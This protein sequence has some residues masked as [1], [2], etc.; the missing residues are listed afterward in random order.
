MRFQELEEHFQTVEKSMKQI[1]ELSQ[2]EDKNYNQ[3]V[4]WVD[5]K[6]LHA[7]KIQEIV[8]QYFMNQRVKPVENAQSDGWDKYVTQTTLLHKMLVESM[9]C[10]QTT[11]VQHVENLRTL[12]E[13][14]E[15]SYFGDEPSAKA[16]KDRGDHSHSHSDHDH[17]H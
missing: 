14:F 7:N 8:Y 10:K 11:D 1:T 3:L 12:L 4:R 6:E 9:K 16:E 5:N 2:A 13:R 17:M 15:K